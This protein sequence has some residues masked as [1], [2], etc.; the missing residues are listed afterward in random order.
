MMTTLSETV[1]GGG[2]PEEL[3]RA[4]VPGSYRAAHLSAEDTDLFFGVQ[5]KDVRKSLRV[6]DVPMPELAPD[7]VLIAA[8]ASAVNYNTVWSA[9]FEPLPT[10]TFLKQFA[11]Q[12]GW[13]ARHDQPYHV[14]GSDCAGVVVR[15]GSGVRR[16]NVGDHVVVSPIQVDDQEPATHGDGMLGEEQRAWGFETNFGA[17]A[18]YTVARASQLIPKPAHLSW[19]EAAVNPLCAGTAYRMLVGRN[20]ARLKQG[21]VVLVWGAAGGLGGYAVQFAKNGGATP[22]GIV[23]SPEKAAAARALGCDLVIDRNEFGLRGD[24]CE[25]PAG[26]VAVGKRLGS[27]IRERT[28]RDPDI[29]FEHV[30]RAT[31]GV[32]LF[33]AARGGVIVTC[34]SS[35]G[36]QHVYDN[37]Y[38]WMRLKRVIGSHA[39]NMQEQFECGDLISSGRIRSTMSALYPLTEIGEAARLVQTNRHLGKIAVLCQAPR[40]GLGVTDP[41]LRARLGADQVAPL[42]NLAGGTP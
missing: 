18:D 25:D 11:R 2:T 7:E 34:G 5:D 30:G 38:L 31:F 36:Y 35:S 16:W 40:A 21:D 26:V 20:G 15:T 41:E 10:F 33:V 12:G 14:V 1:L 19:E 9:M 39:A 13:A 17:L 28:G 32:S 29:V 22:V 42:M 8:M 3:L 37:R 4:P 6:G 23:S 24:S 27:L